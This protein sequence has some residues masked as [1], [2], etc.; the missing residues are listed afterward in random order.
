[1]TARE[2]EVAD[3]G[4]TLHEKLG[5]GLAVIF[6]PVAFLS[7][8]LL[9]SSLHAFCRGRDSLVS[10]TTSHT[11]VGGVRELISVPQ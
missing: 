4:P 5:D 3:D 6:G 9:V 10:V 8:Q 2:G 7:G 1:M 11:P